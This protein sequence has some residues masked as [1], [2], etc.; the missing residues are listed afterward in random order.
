VLAVGSA[1]RPLH[2]TAHP[3]FK[4]A[5][6]SCYLS[7]KL[8]NSNP[9]ALAERDDVALVDGNDRAWIRPRVQSTDIVGG[10][11]SLRK[12]DSLHSVVID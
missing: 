10:R 6:P 5:E 8:G 11:S 3:P 7:D 2:R 4:D 12:P 1:L 9:D